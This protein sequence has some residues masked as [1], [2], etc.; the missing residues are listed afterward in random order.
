MKRVLLYFVLSLAISSQ[1]NISFAQTELDERAVIRFDEGLGFHAPDTCFGLNLRFRMQNRIG[2]STFSESD[3]G[4]DEVDARIRRLRLRLDGYTTN[5]KLTYYIQLSF[6][7]SD[8]DWDNSGVPNIIR[9]AM[10]YYNFNP[11]FY[12]GFGQGK[13]PGNRQRIISSGEQ[14]F[15]DRSMVNSTFNIDR[16]FGVMAYY[17]NSIGEMAYN[18]KGAITGGEGRNAR[19]S[20]NGLA[21]TGRIELLPFGRF[22][23]N[24]DF[25]EGDQF[26]EPTPKLSVAGGYSFNHKA[27]RAGGQRGDFLNEQ[28]DIETWYIDAL[29]K[30][31]GWALYSE[32][33]NRYTDNPVTL[34]PFPLST[35]PV[36]VY[37]GNGFLTQ[38]SYHFKNNF[39]IG[40]RYTKVN[41]SESSLCTNRPL[42]NTPW[43]LRST[44]TNI[45]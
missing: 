25:S 24:G 31:R 6:A 42:T 35:G 21:Y 32:Y 1:N 11:N 27:Q 29:I 2:L 30:Y 7:R 34:P 14:Q 43:A 26:H 22:T 10:V 44:Y 20:D 38:L 37:N 36:Y 23:N 45:G 5:Q 4:I 39:E 16:D 40:T 28:R 8:L 41:P 12:I 33:M 13:L 3:L 15:T 9:D 19:A 17:S 18:L